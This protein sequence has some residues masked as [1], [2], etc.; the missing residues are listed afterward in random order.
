MLIIVYTEKQNRQKSWRIVYDWN[1]ITKCFIQW[2]LG[3]MRRRCE[4]VVAARGAHTHYW[5]PQTPILDDNVCLSM[6]CSVQK[7]L[8]NTSHVTSWIAMLKDVMREEFEDTKG[9]IRI[10]ISKKK[11]GKHYIHCVTHCVRLEPHHKMLYPM[12]A[13]LYAS[14]MRSCRCCKRCSHT[15]LRRVWRY[16]RGNQNPYIEEEKT[17]EKVLKDKQR[18]TKHRYQTKDQA[19]Q[20]PLKPE[21]N[22][23]APYG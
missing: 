18:S 11:R 20:T 5:T 6:I 15:L 19:T 10:R 23:G 3:C 14:E 4:A 13:W 22:S 8:T 17:T 2:L 21:V 12:I 7:V 1:H 9:A 16:Q